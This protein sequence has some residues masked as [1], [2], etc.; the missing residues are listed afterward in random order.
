[1]VKNK[2]VIIVALF[3]FF[4]NLSCGWSKETQDNPTLDAPQLTTE[5]ESLPDL[6]LN[7]I[8]TDDIGPATNEVQDYS[9]EVIITAPE[10]NGACDNVLYPLEPGRNWTYQVKSKGDTSLI[11]LATKEVQENQ[12]TVQLV[13]IGS[14]NSKEY[15]IFCQDG[16]ILNFPIIML[17]NFLWNGIG[18]IDITYVDGVFA[19]SY[20]TLSD[21]GW[22]TAW[23]GNYV[24]TGN[25]NTNINGEP[26]SGSIRDSTLSIQW[27][28]PD[29]GGKPLDPIQVEAGSFTETLHLDRD[30]F[31][32]FTADLE[33][34]G[35]PFSIT[36]TFSLYTT[37]W[38][39]PNIGLL[40]AETT[41]ADLKIFGIDF[42]IE[43][44]STIEL[45]EY[46][47][48]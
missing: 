38:F 3:I 36:G 5:V 29:S 32:N 20:Q 16:A 37:I 33:R 1:V 30:L 12:A 43:I 39:Q 4:V 40:K 27:R 35:N 14:G 45:I 44:E 42:P 11:N 9:T 31:L 23:F 7:T 47:K 18:T 26:L 13:E 34:G 24:A 10:T 41:Q 21:H 46:G 15:T 19:P 22:K 6:N 48:E 28:I 8:E 17:E 25:I 2:S